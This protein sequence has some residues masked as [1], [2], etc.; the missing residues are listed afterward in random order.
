M[1]L[2]DGTNLTC[3]CQQNFQRFPQLTQVTKVVIGCTKTNGCS[4]LLAVEMQHC[5]IQSQKSDMKC[6]TESA[7]QWVC[8]AMALTNTES[9]QA[10]RDDSQI[11]A[12]WQ[13]ITRDALLITQMVSPTPWLWTRHTMKMNKQQPIR[14]SVPAPNGSVDGQLIHQNPIRQP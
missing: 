5:K 13:L 6:M 10:N 7:V 11:L 12:S 1:S 3:A 8:H 9:L 4:A 2:R 14:A